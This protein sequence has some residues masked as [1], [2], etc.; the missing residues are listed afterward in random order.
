MNHGD[1]EGTEI[2]F[3]VSSVSPRWNRMA[4]LDFLNFEPDFN[5]P[6]VIGAYDEV[7]LWSAMSGLLLLE[8]VPLANVTS[9]LDVGCGTGF[10]LIELAE[11]LGGRA[12]VHG[13]DP[14]SGGLKRAAEKIVSRGTKNGTL[15]EGSATG[16]ALPDTTFDLVVSHL[17]RNK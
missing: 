6:Q 2:D 13:I 17:R 1:T 12:H 4:D 3:S 16:I 10:P 14:W 11:R 9:A 5:S 7:A 15:H 8:E